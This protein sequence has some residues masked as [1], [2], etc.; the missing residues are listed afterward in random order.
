[1]KQVPLLFRIMEVKEDESY[2]FT[3]KQ[4]NPDQQLL[5]NHR[6]GC[7]GQPAEEPPKAPAA[8]QSN[9]GQPREAQ[10]ALA[11]KLLGPKKGSSSKLDLLRKTAKKK[12]AENQL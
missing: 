2:F 4:L 7:H 11:Q 3:I 12:M 8:D 10:L 5:A 6:H 9:E 1:M